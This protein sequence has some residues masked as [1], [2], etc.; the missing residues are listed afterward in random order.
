[1][2][3]KGTFLSVKREPGRKDPG[4][5]LIRW[6]NNDQIVTCT[7]YGWAMKKGTP[8]LISGKWENTR[9]NLFCADNICF[10]TTDKKRCV[11]FFSKSRFKGIG[12]KKAGRI[13]EL[14]KEKEE[15]LGL[16]FDK[17]S[18]D[19][20]FAILDQIKITECKQAFSIAVRN[21]YVHKQIQNKMQKYRVTPKD[22]EQIYVS[23]GDQAWQEIIKSP[24]DGM[25][26]NIPFPVCDRIAWDI[27]KR[28]AWDSDRA[29]AIIKQI[30]LMVGN[31]GSCCIRMKDTV[32]YIHNLLNDTPFPYMTKAMIYSEIISSK[33]FVI[34]MTKSYGP[35]VYPKYY[36]YIE[37]DIV[38]EIRRLENSKK[39]LPFLKYR[40][41]SPLDNDQIQA[42]NFL[43]S[44]G[45]KI[46]YGGP[47]AGKT[48]VLREFISEYRKLCPEQDVFLCAP[49]GRA[50]ARVTE[51]CH[52]ICNVFSENG[53]GVHSA[54]TIHK[55]LGVVPYREEM[56]CTMNADNQLPL[57]LFIL[58]E[59][60]MADE[61]M[62]LKFLQAIP[63]G[64]MIIL[65]GD[66]DQLPSVQ[67]GTVLKDLINSGVIECQRL[68]GNH[69]QSDNGRSIVDN[70]KKLLCSDIHLIEDQ[71]FQIIRS[72]EDEDSVIEHIRILY[73]RYYKE[74]SDTF[75]ILT[76]VRKGELGKNRINQLISEW[77]AEKVQAQRK[78][79][80]AV[81]DRVIMT[82]NNYKKGY[83]NGDVGII[84]TITSSGE[85]EV[86]FYDKLQTID[87]EF[88]LDMEH[89]FAITAHKSQGA[90]Y[91]YVVLV[92]DPNFPSMLY[93]S[94]L[95]TAI[96][97]AKEYVF[98][99]ASDEVIQKCI[100]TNKE[101]C[102]ITG[103]AEMLQEN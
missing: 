74:D 3:I 90:E 71:H 66:P 5:F 85:F 84:R 14:L 40:G 47:G 62:F 41:Q 11:R 53:N 72:A 44:T 55:L 96:T 98:I 4:S 89:A 2:V 38:T 33:K 51:S 57:G 43:K 39:E 80:Y 78:G 12:E 92:L 52:G 21:I 27:G 87:Q 73:E 70:Y 63:S 23:Y 25:E 8:L 49:T 32:N 99:L 67:S 36:Y 50:A 93:R 81:G 75:Q 101:A 102:R 69:R 97:R 86:Q 91:R 28:D 19:E 34:R 6:Q 79:E 83:W 82:K 59:V 100:L 54:V 60:S 103:L 95:L 22:I 88:I 76:S 56:D 17:F 68:T 29:K 46:L 18:S 61:I 65:S 42:M 48:T 94:L 24:Y 16:S 31:Q 1:M 30:S 9:I 77:R 45:I 7:G 13:Y 58:D 20:I 35:V 26:F 64:S 10:D 15:E 37:K